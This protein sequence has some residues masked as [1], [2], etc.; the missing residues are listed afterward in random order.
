MDNVLDIKL[1]S[2]NLIIYGCGNVL[3]RAAQF[4]LIPLYTH[5]LS[6]NDYGLLATI[7]I[8][9]QIF[10][11]VIDLGT[12]TGLIRFATEYE[13]KNLIGCLLGSTI[14]INIAGGFIVTG[15]SLLFLLP[16]F[17][18]ILHSDNIHMYVFLA[19]CAA[20]T[21]CL[22]IN[23]L[24]YYRARNEG[25]KY[26][27]ASLSALVILVAFNLLFLL[28]LHKGIKGALM[29]HIIT[30]GGLWLLLLLNVVPKTG[31][32]V[33]SQL[34]WKLFRFGFPLVFAMSGDY[35]TDVS[36]MY[37]LSYFTNLEQVAIYSLG[38]K[39]AQITAIALIIPFQLAYEPFVYANANAP[40]IRVAISKLLTYLIL[41]FA[42]VAFGTA[43]FS[44]DL[45]RVIAPPN[46][47]SAYLIILLILPGIAFRGVYYIGES[48]LNIRNKT[49]VTGTTVTI[50][51]ILSVVANYVLI[52][53]WGI[54]GAIAV[55]NMTVIST[56]MALMI[57]GMKTFPIQIEGRRLGIAGILLICFLLSVFFLREINGFIY[58]SLIPIIALVSLALLYFGK[59]FDDE[60]K[61]L[62]RAVFRRIRLVISA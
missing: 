12:R 44:R 7:L 14:L 4:M 55:F 26:M 37:F 27:I 6:I 31:L 50:A 45:L 56:A 34:Q 39:M 53:I 11:I 28:L 57:L 29:A 22:Y 49:F 20:L 38:C 60:E 32:R 18:N 23:I 2:R 33:S 43:F 47:S 62:I 52:P 3:L 19:C 59:F 48:L 54:Y 17:Q 25:M 13:R 21:Q 61:S 36:I 5:T 42:F 35:V 8:T 15:T 16:F 51:T 24:T 9:I 41:C 40:W 30:Y 58:H 1:I 46:Y 10:T